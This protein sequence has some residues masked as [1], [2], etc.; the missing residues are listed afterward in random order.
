MSMRFGIGIV[1]GAVKPVSV[2]LLG[3]V[4]RAGGYSNR[5]VSLCKCEGVQVYIDISSTFVK[6]TRK[7]LL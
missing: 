1:S 3:P 5:N 4:F 2:L 6:S 7:I